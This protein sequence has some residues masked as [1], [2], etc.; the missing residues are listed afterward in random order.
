[1]VGER[2]A[3]LERRLG[4]SFPCVCFALVAACGSARPI[5]LYPPDEEPLA[6]EIAIL[7]GDVRSVDGKI[8]S[9]HGGTFALRSGCHVVG[10]VTSWGRM[11]GLNSGVTA[12]IP[13]RVYLMPMRGGYHY[14]VRVDALMGSSLHGSLTIK[15]LE[16]DAEGNVT[17]EFPAYG[18]GASCPRNGELPP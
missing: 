13:P 3:R 8:V 10:V 5:P 14:V 16:Q 4:P 11:S 15:G 9:L 18:P 12:T 2:W 17:R 7:H 6:S 1:M